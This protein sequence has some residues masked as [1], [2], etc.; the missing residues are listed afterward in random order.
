MAAKD[1]KK[2]LVGVD[3]SA[4]ALAAFRYAIHRAKTD[5]AALIIT[6]ILESDDYNVYQ[7]LDKDYVHG[8][9]AELENH[10]HAYQQLAQQAGI[11][12]VQAVIGEGDPGETIVKTLIPQYQPDLLIIGAQAKKG[13]AKHFGSQASYMAKHAPISVLVIRE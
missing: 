10:I 13:L 7:A 1:F 3:S 11:H 5:N 6:T 12:D 2:I 8:E 9:A 4:D